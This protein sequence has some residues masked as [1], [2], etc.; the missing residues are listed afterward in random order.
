MDLMKEVALSDRPGFDYGKAFSR[1]IGWVTE[2]EQLSLRGKRV[3][4]A[5]L[6]GV[7]GLHLLTLARLGIGSFKIAEFDRYEVANFNRQVGATVEC[8]DRPMLDVMREMALAI[9]PTLTIEAFDQGIDESNIDAFLEGVDLYVDGF[10]FFVLDIRA[11]VF[12]RCREFGI[13][14]I[15]AAPIGFGVAYLLFTPEGISFGL[16]K[17]RI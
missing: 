11:K 1:N 6:G 13:P 15:T 7:G 2:I 10:D 12:R 4:I 14:A 16:A 9:N 5:G 17:T 3:A 8:L